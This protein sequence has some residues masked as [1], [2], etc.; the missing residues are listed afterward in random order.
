VCL[1]AELAILTCVVVG[2]FMGEVE[3]T[4][5]GVA[6]PKGVL[7]A[8]PHHAKVGEVLMH[9]EVGGEAC[10]YKHSNTA[11]LRVVGP[12]LGIDTLETG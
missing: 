1:E 4:N 5:V 10:V 8:T 6:A 2:G 7:E 3:Y 9:F 12:G 11:M